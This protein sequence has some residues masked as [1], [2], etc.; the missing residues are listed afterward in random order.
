MT[1][2]D[3]LHPLL[4]NKALP[5]GLTRISSTSVTVYQKRFPKGSQESDLALLYCRQLFLRKAWTQ[6]ELKG[7]I[8]SEVHEKQVVLPI[9]HRITLDELLSFDPTLADKYALKT[10]ETRIEEIALHIKR[11]INK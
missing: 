5:S 9:W 11:R 6:H 2:L 4:K 10:S 3:R 1:S 8:T 7:L